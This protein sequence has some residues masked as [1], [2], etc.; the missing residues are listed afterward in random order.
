MGGEFFQV[1]EQEAGIG[2]QSV[3]SGNLIHGVVN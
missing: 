3:K 2:T 1:V